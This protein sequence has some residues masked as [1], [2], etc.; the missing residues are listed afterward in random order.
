M[1]QKKIL[2]LVPDYPNK[3]SH[4]LMYVHVRNK[5]YVKHGITPVVLNFNAKANYTYDGIKVITYEAYIKNSG[6]FDLLVCHAPNVKNHYRF[7]KKFENRFKKII[8]IF[9]GHEILKIN[10]VYPPEY[11]WTGIKRR[12][13]VRNFYDNMKFFLWRKEIK[14]L[15]PKSHL[16][17]VSNWLYQRFLYYVRLNPNEL[18]GKVSIINNSVAEV[19]EKKTY[20]QKGIKKYD[21]LTIRGDSIDGSKYGIDLVCKLAENN[22]K[23]SFLII[24]RGNFFKYNSIPKNVKYLNTTLD[25]DDM[26]NYINESRCALLPTKQDTQGV[27]TCEMATYGVP[28]ITSDID[29]SREVFSGVENVGLIDNAKVEKTKLMPILNKI[30][31]KK[32]SKN[33]KFFAKNTT[34]LEVDLIMREMGGGYVR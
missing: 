22:P 8:F 3:N 5:Y 10:D 31:K 26:L 1:L 25:H 23:N 14:K 30:N 24:G 33:E 13:L 21:F 9:H 15:L 29:I 7:L 12:P 2:V 20:N 6:K 18:D 27:V 19:F 28:T 16:I 4:A 32:A 11:P 34:K 17:F